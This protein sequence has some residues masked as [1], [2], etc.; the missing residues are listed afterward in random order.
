MS[1]TISDVNVDI[2]ISSSFFFNKKCISIVTSKMSL[3]MALI[4]HC[5]STWHMLIERLIVVK[6]K[7][8]LKEN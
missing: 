1:K 8:F 6:T 3:V 5:P 4:E 7:I 2:D